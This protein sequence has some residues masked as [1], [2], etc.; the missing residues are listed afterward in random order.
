MIPRFYQQKVLTSILSA[1]YATYRIAL[2]SL[3]A[4]LGVVSTV[5]KP[6]PSLGAERISFSLP[7]FGEFHLSVDSLEVFAN[8][9]KITKEFYFYAKRFD[10]ETL[11]QLRELLQQQFEISP[12]TIYRLTNTPLGERFLRQMGEVVYTH[13]ER[14]GIY[15]IRAAMILA[16]SDSE[17]LTAIN[18]MRQ[19]PTE[20]IQLNTKLILS[21]VKETNNFLAYTDST[22]TPIPL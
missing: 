19:F 15:A 18:L 20:E 21:L 10:P 6:K 16:A 4:S 11:A 22:V 2:L 1:R 17:G 8:E 14:N 5:L 9:G 3:V 7:V 13:P 12:I